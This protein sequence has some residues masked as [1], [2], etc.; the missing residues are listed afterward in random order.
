MA[1][2]I[3]RQMLQ[4]NPMLTKIR[5]RLVKRLLGD[6]EKKA[7]K[8][9][10]AYETFWET[11]GAVLKEGLYEQADEA[12][13]ILK[14]T[15][16]H[17]TASDGWTSLADYVERMKEGQ[18]AI[19]YISGDDLKT[20]RRSPHIEG[21]RA[22]GIEVLLMTDPVDEFW[23]ASKGSYDDKP[24]RS[25]T[26][27]AADLSAFETDPAAGEK[28]DAEKADDATPAEKIDSVIALFKMALTDAVKDV[29]ISER[30]TDSPV[31]LVA[32]E[33]D[34]DMHIERMLRQHKQ[35]DNV[36]KRILEINPSHSLVRR[37]A[38]RVGQDGA[39]DEISDVAWLLLDQAR[40]I[41]G[42]TLVDPAAFSRRLAGALERGLGSG[43]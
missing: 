35:L 36:S 12:D 3:S 16:C 43:S 17:T 38:D 26:R 18:E 40:I 9:P 10:E 7:T 6:L 33:G 4:H 39:A 28:A 32:D 24:F 41:E 20:L 2:N 27:G 5:N 25:V 30:L 14:L 21:F 31:C 19:Y 8:E 11:F 37:L 29:R 42:E 34:M 15:R 1:L 22:R 23:L 13:Q